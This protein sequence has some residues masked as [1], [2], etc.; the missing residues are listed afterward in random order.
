MFVMLQL[1][2][3]GLTTPDPSELAYLLLMEWRLSL[4][5]SY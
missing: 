2:L 5:P 1:E 4:R 3:R